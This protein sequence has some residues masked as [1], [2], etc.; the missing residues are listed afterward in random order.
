MSSLRISFKLQPYNERASDSRRSTGSG[1]K[2]VLPNQEQSDV[3]FAFLCF[4]I[5][6][7]LSCSEQKVLVESLSSPVQG[8]GA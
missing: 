7:V 8:G 3:T 4:L 6:M 5:S 1:G 2:R